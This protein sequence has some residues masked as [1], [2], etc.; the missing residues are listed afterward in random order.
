MFQRVQK[1]Q[2]LRQCSGKHTEICLN[3]GKAPGR[4]RALERP[5]TDATGD[6]NESKQ[7]PSK[8]G[9][10]G[11]PR[12]R[13]LFGTERRTCQ[14]SPHRF[15]NRL[16]ENRSGYF[17]QASVLA[18]YRG[19]P[20]SKSLVGEKEDRNPKTTEPRQTTV[21]IL[22]QQLIGNSARPYHLCPTLLGVSGDSMS[23][24][25]PIHA[26]LPPVSATTTGFEAFRPVIR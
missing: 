5:E 24:H 9:L 7:Q 14:Q 19:S 18:A 12:A 16:Q 17:L 10:P 25:L 3:M 6:G 13:P 21:D 15:R 1:A 8:F 23:H 4:G 26:V 11:N 20:P 2:F 22:A